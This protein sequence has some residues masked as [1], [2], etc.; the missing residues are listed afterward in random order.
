MNKNIWDKVKEIINNNYKIGDIFE[1]KDIKNKIDSKNSN[2][3]IFFYISSLRKCG[4]LKREISPRYIKLYDV[5][6]GL[7]TN[8]LLQFKKDP[9]LFHRYLKILKIKNTIKN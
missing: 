4:I 7:T 9:I 2:G 8:S 1:P 3:T 6:N 5:P